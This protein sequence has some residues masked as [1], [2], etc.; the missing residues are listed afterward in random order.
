M[1]R[2]ED[3]RSYRILDTA[4][5]TELDDLAE[6]TSAIFDTPISIISFIDDKR[7]WYKAKIGLEENEVRIEDTFC[8]LTLDNPDDILIIDDPTE[9]IR[10]KDNPYVTSEKGIGFYASAPLV[11]K[12][13]NVLGTVCVVDYEKKTF[14]KE[15]YDALRLISK[16]VM[17]YLETRKLLHQQS[18]QIEYNASRLKRITDLVPGVIFKMALEKNGLFKFVF[19]SEGIQQL[20]PGLNRDELKKQPRKILPYILKEDRDH[21][22]KLFKTSYKSLKVIEAEFRVYASEEQQRWIWL[23]VNPEKGSDN[24]VVCFGIIQDIPHKINHLKVL[25]KMIF[26][27]SHV[28]RRPITNI[29]SVANFMKTSEVSEEDKMEMYPIILEETSKL[30]QCINHLNQEYYDLRKAL[31]IEWKDN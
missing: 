6:I 7:Q 11:S 24:E 5:E 15:K 1:D 18:K 12:A 14:K 3:L 16:K 23:K 22:Y 20:I 8:R 27:I 2:L 17:H 28:L 4:P 13:G 19:I 25:E 10:V 29:L 30:D 9:D 31:K 26:D 21:L